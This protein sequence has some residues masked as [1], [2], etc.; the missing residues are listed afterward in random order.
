MVG[1][2]EELF[3]VEEDFTFDEA[4]QRAGLKLVMEKE[5]EGGCALFVAVKDETEEGRVIGMCSVQ[6]LISTAMGGP[7]GLVEDV[8]VSAPRRGRGIGAKLLEGAERWAV[9]NGLTRLHLL[10]DGNN[11]GALEFYRNT[12]WSKTKLVAM[13][14]VL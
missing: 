5:N 1:L 2:L 11:D 4:R 9:E 14:K 3:A 8:V 6:T 12:G 10:T 13:R 7:V